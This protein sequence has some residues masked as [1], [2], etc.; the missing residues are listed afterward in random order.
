MLF[1]KLCHLKKNKTKPFL[2][3]MDVGFFVPLLSSKK[4]YINPLL[5]DLLLV[6]FLLINCKCLSF[7]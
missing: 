2:R 4:Q 5:F 3:K 1:V 7:L 6:C